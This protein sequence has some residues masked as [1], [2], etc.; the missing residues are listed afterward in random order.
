[1]DHIP[2]LKVGEFLLV[3][4]QIELHDDWR[5]RCRTT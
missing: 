1:M 2:I 5:W 4:I 3:T